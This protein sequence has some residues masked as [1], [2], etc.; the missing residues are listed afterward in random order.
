MSKTCTG[1]LI[2]VVSSLVA[3][4]ADDPNADIEKRVQE[5]LKADDLFAVTRSYAKLFKEAGAAGLPGLKLHRNDS[6]AIQAAWQEVALTVPEEEPKQVVRPHRRKLDRFLGFLEGRARVHAPD[7]WAEMLL[8]CRANRR[9]NIYSG[10]SDKHPYEWTEFGRFRVPRGTKMTKQNG[11]LLLRIGE[12][13]VTVSEDLFARAPPDYSISALNAGSR[14]YV[15]LHGGEG[16]SF[17]LICIDGASAEVLWKTKVW[18]IWYGGTSG[19]AGNSWVSIIEKDNRVVLFGATGLGL[20]VEAFRADNGENL[21]R[22][23]T[24]H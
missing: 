10:N 6:I 8:D 15:A 19:P 7:W 18:S 11:K 5:V 12:K 3:V 17:P 20:N 13:S 21:F 2:V 22:F 9:D 1:I 23:C 14:W 24:I 16:Y 4:V